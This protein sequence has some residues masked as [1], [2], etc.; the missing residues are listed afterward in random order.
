MKMH[1]VADFCAG[2]F[3]ANLKRVEARSNDSGRNQKGGLCILK[4][5]SR[6]LQDEGNA[7]FGKVSPAPSPSPLSGRNV[8]QA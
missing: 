8:A 2:V 3:C 4:E 6:M 1:L 7:H 5:V